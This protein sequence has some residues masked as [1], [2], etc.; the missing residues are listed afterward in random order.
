MGAFHPRV[1]LIAG[2]LI[3][4]TLAWVVWTSDDDTAPPTRIAVVGPD[5]V[6]LKLDRQ[7]REKNRYWKLYQDR[8]APEGAFMG[9]MMPGADSLSGSVPLRRTIE[10]GKYYLFVKGTSY[11]R[12]IKV[13]FSLGGGEATT[14]TDDS[15][16]NKYWSEGVP[17]EVDSSTDEMR[18]TLE[19]SGDSDKKEKL[20]LRG[21]YLTTDPTETVLASDRVVALDVPTTM[22]KSAPRP[23][24]LVENASFEAGIGHGWGST[25]DRRFSLASLWDPRAGKDGDASL[26]LP[27]DPSETGTG[28]F[29]AES[30]AIVSKPYS[31]APNKE[32]TL[33]VW[34]NS[35]GGD[36]VEGKIELINSFGPPSAPKLDDKGETRGLSKS[37]RAGA[38]WTRVD[39]TGFLLRYPTAD[40]HVKISAKL[41]PKRH[42]WVDAISL[43][44][45]GPADF[46]TRTPLE[47]GVQ[48]TRPSNIYYDD[49]PVNVRVRAYNSAKR[50]VKRL[51]RYES[52]DFLNRKV[53]AGSRA[54]SVPGD[55]VRTIGLD[56]PGGRR[57][58][59]RLVMWVAGQDG[60]EEEVIYGI[61]PRPRRAGADRASLIGTHSNFTAFQYDVMARLGIKWDRALS[62]A[63]LYRWGDV[64]PEDDK[65]IWFDAETRRAEQHGISV[66]GTLGATDEWPKFADDDGQPNLDEFEE[67]VDQLVTH[68]RGDVSAWEIW[69]EPNSKF[70]PAFY[71]KMLKRG[72]EA[73]KRA[74]PAA[75]VVAM[76]GPD[77]PEYIENV[78]K[79]L[80]SQFPDWEQS[81]YIDQ[82]SMHMYPARVSREAKDGGRAA[83]FRKRILSK[84]DVP[85]WNTESG[86]EDIGFYRTSN[87]VFERWGRNL[88]A[89]GDG[90]R[91][92]GASP[93]AIRNVTTTFLET[94]GNGLSKFFYYDFRVGGATPTWTQG[95]YTMLDYDD[96][97]RPKGVAYAVLAHLFDHS[98]GLGTIELADKSSQAFL[99]DR[100]GVPLVG[101][102]SL[103]GRPRAIR[104]EDLQ[105][106][107]F[108]VFD[109]MGNAVSLRGGRIPFGARP[110]YVE[111][112]G[113]GVRALERAFSQGAIAQRSDD[114]APALS[115][116]Q[117]PRG[118]VD[119]S[120]VRVRWSA[121]DETSIPSSAQPNAITYSHRLRG[122]PGRDKWSLWSARIADEFTALSKGRYRLD[123][124]ARDAA[125]NRSPVVSRSWEIR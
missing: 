73:V 117:A 8:D 44:E 108:R 42:L 43:N 3:V 122:M 83:D 33:S 50:P 16:D 7:V 62:P 2:L 23:G 13:R 60:S 40:Y 95:S 45:G 20:L 15:D 69:N 78:F 1:V 116:D 25:D 46:A 6:A 109:S 114:V 105:R 100:D 37:F 56:L 86:D 94:I 106:G 31:V 47:I 118:A 70:E 35:E 84:H 38:D 54:V 19:R 88:F 26:K 98:K 72:A 71:A 101:I 123:V 4:A 12:E 28:P 64:E 119:A 49:E 51:V 112:N 82:L 59:F 92:A 18:L 103:D 63:V 22:D 68:Y 48:R 9:W 27:L 14:T 36:P 74:D 76:G 57:G 53:A 107:Q 58:T 125:G 61:V 93:A 91:L 120:A 52:Y 79:E 111:G 102:Y 34:L 24:N 80:H 96:T 97:V 110:V 89:A 77:D 30:A 113:I 65:F 41:V 17:I 85:L 104:P 99:F 10:P 66:L 81:R 87:A 39:L 90:I 124:R 55:S 121:T 29:G 32:H 5:L 11:D 21:L 115:I 67:F 75:S